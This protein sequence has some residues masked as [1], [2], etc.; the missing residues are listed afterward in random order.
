LIEDSVEAAYLSG[1]ALATKILDAHVNYV[2]GVSTDG[3]TGSDHYY[4][5]RPVTGMV[6]NKKY[7]E[8]RSRIGANLE[9][10][11]ARNVEF[12]GNEMPGKTSSRGTVD[13]IAALFNADMHRSSCISRSEFGR[14][15]PDGEADVAASKE[16]D[17]KSVDFLRI[18][19]RPET[20]SRPGTHM[21]VRFK[22]DE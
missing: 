8:S 14:S 5:G 19:S 3:Q 22:E 21:S 16:F 10:T 15:S 1:S 2:P 18:P 7:K 17:D 20:R 9:G 12:A 11:P 13:E 6:E 4:N